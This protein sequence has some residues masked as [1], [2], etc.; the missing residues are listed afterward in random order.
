MFTS[1]K[2][3]KSPIVSESERKYN[4]VSCTNPLLQFI[5]LNPDVH[6][7]IMSE[8]T[9]ILNVKDVNFLLLGHLVPTVGVLQPSKF[10]PDPDVTIAEVDIMF[11]SPTDIVSIS[12]AFDAM[13]FNL[14]FPEVNIFASQWTEVGKI[15]LEK[16]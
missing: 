2:D 1:P 4:V 9:S 12:L 14:V 13:D 5:F 16:I 7:P 3:A 10:K 15:T 8:I 11:E 6:V